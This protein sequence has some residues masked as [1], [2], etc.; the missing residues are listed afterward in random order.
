VIHGSRDPRPQQALQQLLP[1]IQPHLSAGTQ[2]AGGSLECADLPL[3][4]QLIA[5]AQ[6]VVSANSPTELWLVP[7]FL[8][9][10]V[11]VRVDLPAAVAA[12]IPQL[13][14]HLTLKITPHLGAHPGLAQL[15]DR[16]WQPDT[17]ETSTRILLSHGSRRPEGN[18]AIAELATRLRAQPAYWST[19]PD[20]GTVVAEQGS[21]VQQ[22]SIFP[23]FLFP[24]SVMDAIMQKIEQLRYQYPQ[25]EFCLA[26]PLQVT[27]QLVTLV[28]DLAP[29][30]QPI[31]QG[32]CP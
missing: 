16:Q 14:E 24:G 32:V 10:G 31:S 22:I 30:P 6:Q 20:L 15:I 21:A 9:P 4:E 27:D 29:L 25:L 8:L 5:F 1:K 26:P 12:A 13:P 7:L 23:Y 3:A 28:C 11:H 18:Q 19:S 2:I 17:V